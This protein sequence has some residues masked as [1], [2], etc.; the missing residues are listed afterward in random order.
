M[1]LKK[2]NNKYKEATDDSEVE[3]LHHYHYHFHG[4]FDEKGKKKDEELILP[5]GPPPEFPPDKK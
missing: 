5:F 2:T 1:I 3:V 4:P